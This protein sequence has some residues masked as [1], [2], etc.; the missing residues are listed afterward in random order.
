MLPEAMS[1]RGQMA[2][3][4]EDGEEIP[5]FLKTDNPVTSS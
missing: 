3:F 5:T 1:K 4:V 2:R